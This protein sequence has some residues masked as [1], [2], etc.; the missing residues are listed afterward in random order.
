MQQK[1]FSFTL[2]KSPPHH[3]KMA[4]DKKTLIKKYD[5]HQWN[6]F[7]FVSKEMFVLQLPKLEN[8]QEMVE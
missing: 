6:Y 7:T 2:D 5:D 3:G 8:V 1:V 4:A